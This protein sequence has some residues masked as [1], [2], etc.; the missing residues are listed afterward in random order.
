MGEQWHWTRDH[1][2]N[3]KLTA[4]VHCRASVPS[5]LQSLTSSH[6]VSVVQT[7]PVSLSHMCVV[8]T[9]QQSTGPTGDLGSEGWQLLAPTAMLR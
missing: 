6:S 3:T 8:H 1:S 9:S 4:V 7:S 2:N 5:A